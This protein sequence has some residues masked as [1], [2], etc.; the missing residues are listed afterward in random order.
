MRRPVFGVGIGMPTLRP[1]ATSR[2]RGRRIP[3][4]LH[5]HAESFPWPTHPYASAC[6]RRRHRD[7]D[8]TSTC[9]I[10]PVADAS[11]RRYIH[12]P[13]RSRGR[14]IPMRRP[15]FGVGIGMPT[16]RPHA[17]SR[18]RGRRI[19]MTLHPH[20]ES[21]PWPTHPYAS[22]CFQYTIDHSPDK[23][24]CRSSG[25][26]SNEIRMRFSH[27]LHRFQPPQPIP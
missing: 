6:F 20:A 27:S 18:S 16:L 10:F 2:S 14:R 1:H 21:F 26:F 13:H 3:M 24:N 22:A 5:P 9:R 4:T 17:A 12:M 23:P 25:Y 19:P 11:L 8:A 15:V 7:A